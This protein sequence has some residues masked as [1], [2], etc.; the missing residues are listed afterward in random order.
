MLFGHTIFFG[1]GRRWSDFFFFFPLLRF[2]HQRIPRPSQ[3][4]IPRTPPAI[5]VRTFLCQQG[6]DVGS[7]A[8]TVQKK[9]TT[10]VMS[11]SRS[12]FRGGQNCP[13]CSDT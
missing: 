4:E 6:P 11:N 7:P 13:R 8:V 9:P 10:S 2:E 1:G 12:G 3:T 5:T